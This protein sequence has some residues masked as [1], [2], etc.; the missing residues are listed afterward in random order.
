F[1][2]MGSLLAIP[3]LVLWMTFAFAA[4]RS[5]RFLIFAASC[6]AVLLVATFN[7]LLGWL[8]G[9]AQTTSGANFALT[10]CGLSLGT[11]WAGCSSTYANEL[12]QLAD[13]RARV[14]FLIAQT[15]DNVLHRPG[16]F[17]WR[18]FENVGKFILS[19]PR[20]FVT[21]YGPMSWW[22]QAAAGLAMLATLPGLLSTFRH[23][24]TASE[25]WFWLALFLGV[26]LSAAV[27]YADDG[28]RAMHVTHAFAA[29]LLALAFAAPGVV[30]VPRSPRWRPQ[31]K[32]GVAALGVMAVLLLLAPF[33]SRAQLG[34]EIAAH[35]PFGRAGPSEDIVLGGRAVTGFLVVAGDRPASI[36]ALHVAEFA[37]LVEGTGI[38]R[39]M[40]PF[41][42][43]VAERAPFAF[44]FA[45]RLDRRDQFDLYLASPRLL[46][47][48]DVW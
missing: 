12:A 25:R 43:G 6:G 44:V 27:I 9:S 20:Y 38:E 15:W 34:R 40:G 47:D 28:W 32:A 22:T 19:Q 5:R 35:P 3:L 30:S 29:C 10:L 4:T 26:L 48:T 31:W 45:P 39:E 7:A 42:V 14:W 36:P 13:E 8:Y 2:R 23:R 33:L 1:T 46:Q 16:P 24:A 21:G 37:R 17:A 18:L 11:D 41:L